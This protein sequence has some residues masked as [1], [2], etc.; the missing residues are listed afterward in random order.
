MKLRNILLF[1][2]SLTQIA[3]PSIWQELAHYEA[4]EYKKFVFVICSCNNSKWYDKN[5]ES[6][7]MQDYP[8]DKF[9]FIYIDESRD[10]TADLV[11]A[12]VADHNESDRFTLIRNNQWQ[13]VMHNHY[14]AAHMCDDDEILVHL[15]GDDF[16]SHYQ[17]LYLLNKV[18]NYWDVWL[19]YGQYEEWPQSALGFSV[20]VPAH[21]RANNQFRE[22]GFWYS[23]LR[24]CYAWLFKKIQLKEL[25]I[26]FI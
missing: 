11:E 8:R 18:Y 16:T 5:L 4:P 14:K 21:I 25:K 17:V 15:D 6:A 26:Y 19:T 23:H 10:G 7:F 9:R 22:M 24:T 12:Y 2:L 20:D 3:L 1:F 13:S